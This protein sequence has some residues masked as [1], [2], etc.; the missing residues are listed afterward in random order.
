MRELI[1]GLTEGQGK[2]TWDGPVADVASGDGYDKWNGIYDLGRGLKQASHQYELATKYAKT[3]YPAKTGAPIAAASE[4]TQ[5]TID[6]AVA[7]L[8]KAVEMLTDALD[9]DREFVTK[10][11]HPNEI[12]SKG[13]AFIFPR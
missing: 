8:A 12:E 3:G 9:A 4:K 10:F 6:A 2:L 7:A 11:G 1:E 5:D 13:R